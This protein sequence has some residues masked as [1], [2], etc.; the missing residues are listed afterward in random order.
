MIKHENELV[1]HRLTWMLLFH[2]FLLTSMAQVYE[3][4]GWQGIWIGLSLLGVF[5]T[6][7]AQTVISLSNRAF[8]RWTGEG[9]K[10]NRESAGG[11]SSEQDASK[12]TGCKDANATGGREQNPKDRPPDGFIGYYPLEHEE[13]HRFGP[14]QGLFY[15]LNEGLRRRLSV[16]W[17]PCF[18]IPLLALY[19]FVWTMSFALNRVEWLRTYWLNVVADVVVI[20]SL[21]LLVRRAVSVLRDC[22]N[23][24]PEDGGKEITEPERFGRPWIVVFGLLLLF[25]VSWGAGWVT[26]YLAA[27]QPTTPDLQ[28]SLLR[29]RNDI[30]AIHDNA[31]AIQQTETAIRALNDRLTKLK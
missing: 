30:R 18:L 3:K 16:L 22:K 5:V 9:W 4:P 29:L 14:L 17:I 7:S 10:P 28:V 1:N 24:A 12:T 20:V 6:V 25:P 2:G 13:P 23:C 15:G 19:L 31:P 27:A 8:H 26:A 11:E 21:V